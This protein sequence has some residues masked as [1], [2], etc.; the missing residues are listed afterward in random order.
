MSQMPRKYEGLTSQERFGARCSE[1][2]MIFPP[3]LSTVY[4]TSP[5]TKEG[6]PEIL[7][8]GATIPKRS[9]EQ[10]PEGVLDMQNPGE[11][12]PPS[13]LLAWHALHAGPATLILV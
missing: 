2:V 13:H 3:K 11:R 4:L 1:C 9:R 6:P 7:E 12:S 10:R 5:T 8:T